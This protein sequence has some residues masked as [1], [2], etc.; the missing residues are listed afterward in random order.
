MGRLGRVRRQALAEEGRPS[1]HP[2]A[3]HLLQLRIGVW[4]AG[5]RRQED[6]RDPQVRGQPGPSGLPRPQLREGSGDPQPDLRPG[7]HPLP[8]QAGREAGRGQVEARVLGRG[9]GRHRPEDARLPREASRRHH[10]PRGSARRGPLHQPGHHRVGC[11]RAQLPHQ[12]L[13]GRRPL[14]V[15]PLVGRGPPEP[16]PCKRP[17][18]PAGVLTPRDRPLLQSPRAADHRSQDERRE[19]RDL[20]PPALEHRSQVGRLAAVLARLGDEHPP[21]GRQPP[22]PDRPL[23]QGLRPTLG[24]LGGL[25]HTLPRRGPGRRLA[26][27]GLRRLPQGDLRRVHL[28]AGRRWIPGAH[29]SHRAH[30]EIRRPGGDRVDPRLALGQHGQPHGWQVS[31]CLF[32]IN[33]LTGSVGTEGGTA[34]LL[35]QV[36]P[37]RRKPPRS[38]PGTNC[39][40]RTS[41]RS[42][43]PR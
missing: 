39:I 13:L 25:A 40:C 12:H 42:P 7:A 29:R 32:F 38:T 10:V 2:R 31:R 17:G 43:S 3:D 21:G 41:G 15:L 35:E 14:R 22:H 6:L 11:R 19:D 27:Q 34:E 24:Q 26:L 5:L 37:S 23:Q 18:H 33:V 8:P 28:R 4:A 30:R 9:D 36:R 20:R 1:L 16:G